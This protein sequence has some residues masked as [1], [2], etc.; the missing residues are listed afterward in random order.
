LSR[1]DSVALAKKRLIKDL[2]TDEKQ[3][4]AF[5]DSVREAFYALGMIY[6]ERLNDLKE[7][8]KTFEEFLRKYPGDVSEATV[9]YQLYRIFLKMPDNSNAEKYRNLLLSKF[10]DSEYSL[11]IKDP[12]FFAASNMSKKE[13]ETFYEETYRLYKARE[14]KT[15]LDR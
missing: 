14:Y 2:P 11:I 15:V 5:A 6:R 9:Y 7:S 3:K 4:T 8:A 1:E 12:N 13:T 10:P